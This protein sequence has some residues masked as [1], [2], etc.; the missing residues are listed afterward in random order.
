GFT[1]YYTDLVLRR[2]G[3]ISPMR[4]LEK[5]A[6]QITRFAQ[7]PG[8]AVQS[9]ED[10]SFDTWIKFYRPDANTPNATISY[11]QKG[12]LVAL[13]LDMEIRARTGNARSLDDVLRL[14]WERWGARDV[15]FPEGTVEAVAAEVAGADLSDR[16]DVWLRSTQELDYSGLLHTAGLMLMTP[17]EARERGMAPGGHPDAPGA[18][19]VPRE[20]RTGLQLKPE[21]GRIVVSNVQAGSAA[22]AAGVNAGDELVALD[23]ARIAPDTLTA[24]LAE[25]R[26]GE[27][28]PLTV[29]RR[30][31]LLTLSLP[32]V[33]G[34]PQTLL[35]RPSPTATPE[36]KRVLTDWLR[37]DVAG[38]AQ[39]APG[40][41]DGPR[42]SFGPMAEPGR[43]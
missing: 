30:D 10:S 20:P 14:L 18:A 15:G 6:E 25:R 33:V 26:H 34:P 17:R 28:L 37:M 8:R 39:P 38:A 21:G 35:L 16:F 12:A 31:E 24:R 40:R 7:L 5:L 13:L 36:Q 32:V 27:R 4:Y 11:Y 3:L 22:W 9:L 42:A 43:G 23:G 29:F 41:A 1:T 19:P 2:A